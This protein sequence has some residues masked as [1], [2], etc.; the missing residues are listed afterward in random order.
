MIYV[1]TFAFTIKLGEE[2]FN[3]NKPKTAMTIKYNNN[4]PYF[5]VTEN[6]LVYAF[7][8]M[9]RA[10]QNFYDESYFSI[11]AS[12]FHVLRGENNT[13]IGY[14]DIP[15]TN[16]SE[17]RYIYENKGFGNLFDG[18]SLGDAK[19]IDF[20]K[21]NVLMGGAFATNSFHNILFQF[22]R[23]VNGTDAICKPLEVIDEALKGGYFQLTYIDKYIDLNNYSNPIVEY[24]SQYFIITD[25]KSYKFIDTFFQMI[26]I[27]SYSGI[28]FDDPEITTDLKFDRFREQ[29]ET[30]NTDERIV[31]IY[32]NSSQNTIYYT[33][34]YMKIQDLAAMIGGLLKIMLFVG[35]ILTDYFTRMRMNET[36]TNSL[37]SFK[38]H[39][40]IGRI[41]VNQRDI[42]IRNIIKDY[43]KSISYIGYKGTFTKVK[44]N[45]LPKDRIK[46]ELNSKI[47]EF[48]QNSKSLK[49]SSIDILKLMFCVRKNK[50]LELFNLTMK[51]NSK[52]LDFINII[53]TLQQFHKFKKIIFNNTQCELFENQEKPVID[54]KKL[55]KTK[56]LAN[57]DYYLLYE[58]YVKALKKGETDKVYEKLLL[59]LDSD[60]KGVFEKIKE[61]IIE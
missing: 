61:C 38:F 17:Y 11:K 22:N 33:R 58:K 59:N 53:H 56:T 3:K 37:Y 4:A 52:Y 5:N 60:L 15:L 25:P 51:K 9:N 45:D 49:L 26:Q 1:A 57:Q 40:E 12:Q 35:S 19:C 16:C 21:S 20:S 24:V 34:S 10:F 39:E 50:K 7:F 2:L 47:M 41:N 32:I 43:N 46:Q 55:D 28:V 36:I 44:I 48:K 31:H 14:V 8:F 54:Y 27:T 23:C 30:S 6:K 42:E 29:F 18:N 13:D